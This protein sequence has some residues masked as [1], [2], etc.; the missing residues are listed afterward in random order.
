MSVGM[1]VSVSVC[2]CLGVS[3]SMAGFLAAETLC[4]AA[5]L[6]ESVVDRAVRE[7]EQKQQQAL[8]ANPPSH[9]KCCAVCR[10]GGQHRSTTVDTSNT[11]D[12]STTNVVLTQLLGRPD[13]L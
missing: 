13:F 5:D 9:G 4:E 1:S 7:A 2:L 12:S 8:N 3:V 10:C 11:R 6:T